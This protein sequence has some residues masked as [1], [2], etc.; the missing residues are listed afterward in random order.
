[1]AISTTPVKNTP[2][3]GEEE[4]SGTTTYR[5]LPSRCFSV[6][7]DSPVGSAE[8]TVWVSLRA[9]ANLT[10]GRV[11][12]NE[13]REPVYVQV[14]RLEPPAVINAGSSGS[15]GPSLAPKVLHAGTA[16]SAEDSAKSKAAALGHCRLGGS[17]AIPENHVCI[18]LGDRGNIDGARDWDLVRYDVKRHFKLKNRTDPFGVA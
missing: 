18:T 6:V 1:M 13:T 4:T 15:E 2:V 14:R 8:T 7:S 10:R 12:S 5:L 9:Y 16:H 11:Q 3:Q 17:S